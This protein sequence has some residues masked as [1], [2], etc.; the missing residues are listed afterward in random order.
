MRR[1]DGDAHLVAGLVAGLVQAQLDLVRARIQAPVFVVPAPA[2]VEGIAAGQP[3]GRI[4]HLQ[5]VLAPLHR[6]VDRGGC[7]AGVDGAGVLVLE[8]AGEVV[9]P[10][11][12]VEGPVVVAQLAHQGDLQALA[13]LRLAGRIHA[14]DFKARVAVG[15]GAVFGVEQRAHADQ[16]RGRPQHPLQGA[17]DRAAAGFIHAAGQHHRHRRA[18][19]DLGRQVHVLAQL[20]IGREFGI[21]HIARFARQFQGRVA[22]EVARQRFH[23]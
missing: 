16:H 10:A 5:A 6:Q 18:G 21:D 13:R 3:G 20:A 22:E 14:H 4:E 9:I 15:I 12:V 23:R 11:V 19:L 1:G 2:G 8:A 7:G 17:A